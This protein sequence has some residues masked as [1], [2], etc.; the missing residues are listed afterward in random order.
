MKRVCLKKIAVLLFRR[1]LNKIEKAETTSEQ[2]YLVVTKYKA[3]FSIDNRERRSQAVVYPMKD[4]SSM[5]IARVK[6]EEEEVVTRK[7]TEE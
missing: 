4:T 1:G 6:Q 2:R 5:R 7:L 3:F